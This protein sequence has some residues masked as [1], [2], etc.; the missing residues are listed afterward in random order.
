VPEEATVLDLLWLGSSALADSGEDEWVPERRVKVRPGDT[1]V[2][3]LG[4]AGVPRGEAMEWSQA[5]RPVFDFRKL[6]I[7]QTITL[8]FDPAEGQE[9]LASLSFQ[10]DRLH[11]LF[12]ERGADGQLSARKEEVPTLAQVH[13]VAGKIE[14]SMTADCLQAGTPREVVAEMSRIFMPAV[15]FSRLRKGD[16]FRVLYEVRVGADGK[17]VLDAGRVLAAEVRTGGKVH[18][19]IQGEQEDGKLVYLD[20]QGKPLDSRVNVEAGTRPVYPLAFQRV[21]SAFSSSRLHPILRRRRPH[22]GVDFAAPRGTAVKA[23]ADGTIVYARWYGQLGRAVRIDHAQP[24]G[25][26]SIYGHL[27]GFAKNLREGTPV[28]RGDVIGYVGSTGLATG[29]HLHFALVRGSKYVDPLKALKS[30]PTV[31][32]VRFDG[33][34]FQRRKAALVTALDEL[35]GDGPVRLKRLSETLDL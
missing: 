22:Y 8:G 5:V 9:R 14:S 20:L 26:D 17:E 13:G 3:L 11:L 33:A 28:R 32:P 25:Y 34:E 4:K 29:P 10:I 12:A 19:A 23:I 35:D 7:G 2:H 6:R 1:F 30:A 15:R 24:Y 16:T 21:S 31:Q 27:S 18:T